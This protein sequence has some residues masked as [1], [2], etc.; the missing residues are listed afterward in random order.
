MDEQNQ[1][2]TGTSPRLYN[3]SAGPP[4]AIVV[5]C[6][7]PRFQEA[8]EEFL[9]TELKLEKGKYIPIVISGAVASLSEPLSFPQGVQGCERSHRTLP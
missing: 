3:A 5:H 4:E 1:K 2:P 8:F 7:D 6:A 9:K